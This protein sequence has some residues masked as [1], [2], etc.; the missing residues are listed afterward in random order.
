[1]KG[2]V[3]SPLKRSKGG[4]GHQNDGVGVRVRVVVVSAGREGP[5]GPLPPAL[6]PTL[7]PTLAP[8]LPSTLPPVARAHAEALVE[9]AEGA[10]IEI[11]GAVCKTV[12]SRKRDWRARFHCTRMAASRAK[13]LL[14]KPRYLAVFSSFDHRSKKAKS[15]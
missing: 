1:M 10:E 11:P 4:G 2:G 5:H 8:A 12:L 6:A 9:G 7:A 3:C 15:E 14:I 13:F